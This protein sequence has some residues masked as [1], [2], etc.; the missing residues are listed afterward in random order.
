VVTGGWR[1]LCD[2]QLHDWHWGS[3]LRQTVRGK[4]AVLGC[5]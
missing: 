5:T 4:W 3:V 2:E 1:E